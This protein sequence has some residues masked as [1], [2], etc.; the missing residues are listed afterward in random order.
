MD[1]EY[2]QIEIKIFKFI[3]A[4]NKK[5]TEHFGRIFKILGN[6]E[7][8]NLNYDSVNNYIPTWTKN[9]KNYYKGK[10]REEYFKLDNEGGKLI[11]KNGAGLLL[12]INN[13]IFVHGRLDHTKDFK[14]YEDTNNILN[15]IN[16][17]LRHKTI[18]E[19]NSNYNITT[20]GRKYNRNFN[21]YND[22]DNLSNIQNIKCKEIKEYLTKLIA[23][24]PNN[25]YK[26]EDMRVVVGH[27][28]QY[29]N[30]NESYQSTVN[31]T[32]TRIEKYGQFEKLTFPVRTSKSNKNENFI[33][34]IGMECNKNDLDD[35]VDYPNYIDNDDRKYEDDYERYIYKV[36]VG[37]SRG[38]D[39]KVDDILDRNY[40]KHNIGSRVSQVLEFNNGEINILR[41]TIKNTR[42]HQPR[43]K[44]EK[45]IKEKYITELDLD[46]NIGNYYKKYIK[47]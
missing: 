43:Q 40:E 47:V 18:R 25:K 8:I 12:K 39:R 16:N 20:W 3:N 10:T 41:S 17:A 36:D 13:N 32:F 27:C 30:S 11:F 33:F 31:S 26:V 7:F 19:L 34:G 24:I 28:P 35:P 29:L 21:N 1:L 23:E 37:S 45:T 9:L 22:N 15:D 6:H 44:Y 14:Y 2:D 42:I 38:F 4:I 46:K 5:A